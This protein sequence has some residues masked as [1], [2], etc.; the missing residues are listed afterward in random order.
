MQKRFSFTKPFAFLALLTVVGGLVVEIHIRGEERKAR[1]S[2]GGAIRNADLPD[3]AGEQIQVD[4][5]AARRLARCGD[6][7][8]AATHLDR[9]SSQA[10]TF[11]THGLASLAHRAA[12]N[13]EQAARHAQFAAQLAPDDKRVVAFAEQALTLAMFDAVRPYARVFGGISLAFLLVLFFR[14]GARRHQE[15]ARRRFVDGIAG[16]V[17]FSVDGQRARTRPTVAP[18]SDRLAVDIFLSGRYGMSC[19]R[20]PHRGLSLHITASNASASRTVR[21]TPVKDVS[22]DAVRVMVKPETLARLKK[23]A[24]RWRFQVA[25]DDRTIA[26]GHLDVAA[27]LSA[28]GA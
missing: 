8:A 25:L 13:G 11:T 24:G 9:I 6:V 1:A 5:N 15:R 7:S 28:V 2:L 27:Q 18:D 20:R 21:L 26:V 19:P 4:L 10:P 22:S 17:R 16:R 14:R 3:T 12:G 23:H